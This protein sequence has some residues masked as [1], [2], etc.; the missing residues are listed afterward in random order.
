MA[1]FAHAKVVK[2]LRRGVEYA[3]ARLG[4]RCCRQ[5]SV[6]SFFRRVLK[7]E[8]KLAH[9]QK[10]TPNRQIKKTRALMATAP[11]Q[12][13]SWDITYLPT[14]VRDV[15]LYLYLVVDIYSR[16]IVGWQVYEKESSALAPI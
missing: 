4:A 14:A 15:F 1:I 8:K 6:E 3:D 11:N 13:C 2:S 10:S 16:K 9:R 7:A 5:A 12:L